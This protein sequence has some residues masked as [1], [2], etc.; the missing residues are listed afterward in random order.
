[1]KFQ[2]F[3]RW[4]SQVYIR[5]LCSIS[6]KASNSLNVNRSNARR[7][8]G[9]RDISRGNHIN[10]KVVVG[11][12]VVDFEIGIISL[13]GMRTITNLSRNDQIR[14]DAG[15]P[16]RRRIIVGTIMMSRNKN[17]LTPGK[18]DNLREVSLKIGM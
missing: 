17:L 12:K 10:T 3:S 6:Y 5:K 13:A 1:M 2:R 9:D 4:Y 11:S 16:C 14:P 15:R 8:V 7:T 18:P